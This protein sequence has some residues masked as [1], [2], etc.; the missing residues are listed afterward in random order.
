[1]TNNEYRDRGDVYRRELDRA[2]QL[3][4]TGLPDS[5]VFISQIIRESGIDAEYPKLTTAARTAEFIQTSSRWQKIDPT[6]LQAGDV[7]VSEGHTLFLTL[8]D[9]AVAENIYGVIEQTQSLPDDF[10]AYRYTDHED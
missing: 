6:E 1:M 5:G 2:K 9:N 7:I 3:P 8:S 10:A 4:S